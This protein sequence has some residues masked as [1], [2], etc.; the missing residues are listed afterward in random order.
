MN[1]E[2]VKKIN[3]ILFLIIAASVVFYIFLE[4][5]FILVLPFLIGWFVAFAMRPMS[6]Y[7]ARRLG[8]KQRIIRLLLTVLCILLI[9]GIA[10]VC[11]W[12]LSKEVRQL[13][14]GIGAGSIDGIIA[15]VVGSDG[16]FG[17]LFGN[18]SEYV[19]DGIYSIAMSLLSSLGGLLSSFAAAVPR[20]V[21]FVV[22]TLISSLYFSLELEAVNRTVKEMF[23]ERFYSVLVKLKNGF[24]TAFVRYIKAYLFLLVITFG[25]MLVGLLI[26]R[27]PYPVLMAMLIA[28][29]DLLPILGVGT[30][31]IPWA[32]GAF[33]AGKSGLGAGLLLLFIIHTVLRQIIEPKIVGKNLGVHPI[34]TLVFIYVGYSL[35]GFIGLI[36]VPVFTVLVNICLSKEDTTEIP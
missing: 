28:V 23:P 12:M 2:K 19:A 1:F 8:I 17:R 11:V 27:A 3:S 35:F 16:L 33:I 32:L 10:V 9:I 13:L 15:S 5:V 26:I 30:V 18:F 24:L 6:V 20:V 36:M 7:L 4:Y 25:E 22:I 34:L 29:L 14:S 31:L 21:L